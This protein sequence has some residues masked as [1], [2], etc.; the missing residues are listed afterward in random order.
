MRPHQ[1]DLTAG[2]GLS[3]EGDERLDESPAEE[4]RQE[5][6]AGVLGLAGLPRCGHDFLTCFVPISSGESRIESR[7]PHG[8][9]PLN[10]GGNVGSSPA[11]EHQGG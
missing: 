4:D 3:S 7:T 10:S 1:A 5:A 9:T 8:K 2:A 11:E 6:G